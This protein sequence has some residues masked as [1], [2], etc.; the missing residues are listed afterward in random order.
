MMRIGEFA[1]LCRV[2]VK[3]L[4]YYDEMGLI[5]PA[6]VD[7]FT[8]YRYYTHEQYERLNR[9]LALKD[10]G[11]SLDHIRRLLDG[12]LTAEQ[13]HA[14]LDQQASDI[15]R[16]LQEDQ[17]RLARI[18]AWQT[19]LSKE[20]FMSEYEI[21]VKKVPATRVATV[22][23]SV[24]TPPE[25]DQLWGRLLAG[26]GDFQKLA[27]EP[28]IALY[29]DPEPPEQ[30][31]DIEVCAPVKADFAGGNGVDVKELPAVDSMASV[32]H[33]GPFLTIGEAYDALNQWVGSN[34]YR[35]TGPAREVLIHVAQCDDPAT[36]QVQPDTVVEVQ[37]PIEAA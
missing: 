23:G 17:G 30:E 28:F 24:A 10:L 12:G 11:F 3:T 37:M 8:G 36:R 35:V 20:K 29:H 21:L 13:M 16:R 5:T 9:L 15:R 32:V 6:R 27:P 31:W 1:R 26:I 14:M 25:Q 34:G 7:A 18:E 33:K 22:R 19:Q 4:Q 2:S